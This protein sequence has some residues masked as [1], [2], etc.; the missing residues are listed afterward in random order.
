MRVRYGHV[1]VGAML[2]GLLP[3]SAGAGTALTPT[4]ERL[5]QSV[6]A[7]VP[8]A[9]ALLRKAVDINS[10]TMNFEGVRSVGALFRPGRMRGRAVRVLVRLPISFTL[11]P[12]R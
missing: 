2:A 11:R 7:Q 10:G 6:D 5:L 1:L 9:L 3:A 8:A 4:E 12:L